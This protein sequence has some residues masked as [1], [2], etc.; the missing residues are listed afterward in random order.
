MAREITD[1]YGNTIVI[2]D[3]FINLQ[4]DNAFKTTTFGPGFDGEDTDDFNVIDLLNQYINAGFNTTGPQGTSNPEYKTL[5]AYLR[6]LFGDLPEG[7]VDWAANDLNGDG[8]NE[9]YAVDADGNAHTV[10]GYDSDGNTES[11]EFNQ[12]QYDSFLNDI[13]NVE[14]DEDFLDVVNRYESAG[15]QN[16]SVVMSFAGPIKT[17]GEDI[18]KEVFGESGATIGAGVT[19]TVEDIGAILTGQVSFEDF[20]RDIFILTK[21]ILNLPIP[22]WL[23]IPAVFKLP[24]IGDIWDKTFGGIIG[25]VQDSGC[26]DEE[27]AVAAC[28]GEVGDAVVGAVGDFGKTVEGKITDVYCSTFGCPDTEGQPN[29]GV[30]QNPEEG[31][32]QVY[33]WLKGIFGEDPKNMPPWVW[34]VVL[35]GVFGKEILGGLEDIFGDD[36]NDDGTIGVPPVTPVYGPDNPNPDC[37]TAGAQTDADGN[38]VCS[39][40]FEYI[41]A[42]TSCEDA[43]PV[44]NTVEE[45]CKQKGRE[46]D[47]VTDSCGDCKLQNYEPDEISGECAEVV[48]PPPPI[49]CTQPQ[50]GYT[51]SFNPADNAAH[52]E[53]G[54]ACGA[55][56]CPDGSV[57]PESGVCGEQPSTPCNNGATLESDCLE[58]PDGSAPSAH[59][60]GDCAKDLITTT[61]PTNVFNFDCSVDPR[62]TGALTF[63]LIDQQ[64]AWDQQ[65]GGGGGSFNCN[66]LNRQTREDGSCGECL[67]GYVLDQNMDNCVKQ[68]IPV[69]PT[70]TSTETPATGGGASVG[71]GAGGAFSPFLAGITYTPQ[72]VPE[73][74]QQP[75][76]MFTGAQPRS[77]TKAVEQSIVKTLLPE[78]FA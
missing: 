17:S 27:N 74:I 47:E 37:V 22:D 48:N 25:D 40:G 33:D 50:P 18:L 5:E 29:E 44:V 67:P 55:T 68:E 21:G 77:N 15:I 14:T 63:D 8:V 7:A 23:P 10:Y 43:G 42:S 58:C 70:E 41:E 9:L 20:V 51:P 49:D 54:E 53:W 24:T 72:P 3:P 39:E 71:G 31:I 46:Y 30:L 34:G 32:Q 52:F 4:G 36:V 11:S 2:P 62:P 64:K 73:V 28:A 16:N 75:S 38:C 69:T 78:Y 13:E 61:T 6:Y 12:W 57:K 1:E 19:I 76:G 56:H 45:D 66:S 59:E 26:I 65:C 35:G 60:G